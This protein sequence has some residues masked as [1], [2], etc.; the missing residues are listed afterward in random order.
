M[1]TKSSAFAQVKRVQTQSKNSQQRKREEAME[2]K[3]LGA[4]VMSLA[5]GLWMVLFIGLSFAEEAKAPAAAEPPK[6][7]APA[8]VP[9]APAAGAGPP[10]P[11]PAAP[12]AAAPPAAPAPKLPPYFTATSPDPKNQL[13]PDPTG[14]NAG[15]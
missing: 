12:A 1:S 11:F 14:G 15:V 13:W 4:F 10:G 9:A 6:A 8:A 2:R 3:R 5:A 7:E